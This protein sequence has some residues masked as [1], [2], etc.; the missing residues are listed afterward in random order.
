MSRRENGG[1]LECVC[2]GTEGKP[3]G[4][5]NRLNEVSRVPCIDGPRQFLGRTRKQRAAGGLDGVCDFRKGR[6]RVE[7]DVEEEE[8]VQR[9]AKTFGAGEGAVTSSRTLRK[10]RGR[11]G[12]QLW[13]AV[14]PSC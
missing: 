5:C 2:G 11:G 9:K 3:C 4:R 12:N 7:E 6:V 13:A 10:G 14:V 8:D 1:R